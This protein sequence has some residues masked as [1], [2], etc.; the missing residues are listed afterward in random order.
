MTRDIYL[1][2][3]LTT[4]ANL[5]LTPIAMRITVTSAMVIAITAYVFLFSFD[6][7]PPCL[8]SSP[9]VTMATVVVGSFVVVA[10]VVVAAFVVT[11]SRHFLDR[12]DSG[13]CQ[14]LFHRCITRCAQICLS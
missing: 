10:A 14:Y 9:R 8:Y 4:E 1:R 6:S 5:T 12:L 13:L 2:D 7:L 3:T 11:V